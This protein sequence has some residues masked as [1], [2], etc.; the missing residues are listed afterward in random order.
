MKFFTSALF[1][2]ALLAFSEA[3]PK[4]GK[5]QSVSI[6]G[7]LMCDDKGA[8]SIRIKLYDVDTLTLDDKMGETTTDSTGSFKI[9]GSESAIFHIKPKLNIYHKCGDPTMMCHKKFSIR[10]PES[11]ISEG[12][13]AEKTFDLGTLNLNGKFSGESRDCVNR[14]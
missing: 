7:K 10:I 13:T 1:I 3:L 2:G 4:L 9:E 11:Y 5:L 6:K 12:E 8:E 14:R